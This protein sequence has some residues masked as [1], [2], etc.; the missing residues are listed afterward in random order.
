MTIKQAF[1]ILD[2]VCGNYRGTR[3]DHLNISQALD[4]IA[5]FILKHSP[6]EELTEKQ[7][8]EK[9]EPVVT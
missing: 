9:I 1:N 4:M 7:Q 5:N 3:E 2:K 6:K 8:I